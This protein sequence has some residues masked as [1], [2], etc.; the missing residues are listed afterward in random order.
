MYFLRLMFCVPM[1]IIAGQDTVEVA[2]GV[3]FATN[4]TSDANNRLTTAKGRTK[5][6]DKR[7]R[8]GILLSLVPLI[9]LSALNTMLIIVIL[10][11]QRRVYGQQ[12]L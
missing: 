10:C 11:L 1:F 5:H 6:M 7:Q 4:A 9:V 12:G 2:T 8:I 3:Q